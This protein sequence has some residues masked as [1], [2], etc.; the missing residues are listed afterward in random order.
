MK[1]IGQAAI[2][3]ENVR[4]IFD[5]I[6]SSPKGTGISRAEIAAATGLSLMTV[7]KT[8]DLLIG[9]GVVTQVKPATGSAGRRTGMLDLSDEYFIA[10]LDLSGNVFRETI[11]DLR[12][13][14]TGEVEYAVSGELMPEDDLIRALQSFIPLLAENLGK[15]SLVG[16]GVCVPGNYD[17]ESDMTDVGVL[18]GV[19]IKETIK[20]NTGITPAVIVN[21]LRAAS[22]AELSRR[23]E[24]RR[25]GSAFMYLD[26]R[27]AGCIAYDGKLIPALPNFP[28]IICRGGRSL[29]AELDSERDKNKLCGALCSALEAVIA[30]ASPERIVLGPG[31]EYDPELAER[32]RLGIKKMGL[33]ADISVSEPASELCLIGAATEVREGSLYDMIR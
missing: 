19:K 29:G 23:Q 14:K 11:F 31:A 33:C 18:C 9:K 22:T 15:R 6:E 26:K 13:V 16:V 25:G 27:G 21:D 4:A 3:R 1:N 8:A 32:L 17:D 28:S 7:G 2:R 10:V 30:V 12:L 5:A 20:K 24:L